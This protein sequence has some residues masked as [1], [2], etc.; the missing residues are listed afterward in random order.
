MEAL[1][2]NLKLAMGD[3]IRNNSW[4]APETKTAALAKLVAARRSLGATSQWL[5]LVGH[6]HDQGLYYTGLDGQAV[7]FRP[8]PGVHFAAEHSGQRQHQ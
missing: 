8:V 6:V 1:V 2:V 7:Y 4:M 3:R 5:T